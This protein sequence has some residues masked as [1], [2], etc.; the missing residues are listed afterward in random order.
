M[1]PE[2]RPPVT[3]ATTPRAVRADARPPVPA[4]V[5]DRY[6][7]LS[8]WWRTRPSATRDRELA[9]V[10]AVLSFAAP[11]DSVGAQFGDLPVRQ[12]G[13][14]GVLLTLGQTLPL[15][16]R[17]RRPALCLTLVA[18]CFALHQTCAHPPNIGS[19]GLYVALYSV[20][21]HQERWR[22]LLPVP[23]VAAYGVFAVVLWRLDSPAGIA[24]YA[25][26]ALALAAFWVAGAYVRARRAEEAERRRLAALAATAEERARLARELH[27]VVTHHVTAMVVQADAAQYLAASPDRLTEG[28]TAISGTGRRA[29]TELRYLLG[30]LEATGESATA[31]RAPVRGKLSD[32]VEQTRLSGQPVVLVEEGQE[33]GERVPMGI[34]GEL[35]AYRVVQESLTNAVKYAAGRPTRVRVRYGHDHMDIE[36]TTDGP[37]GAARAPL[38]S[39]AGGHV[40]GGRGLGG[41]RE[42]VDMLGGRFTA[43]AGSDGGFTVTARIPVG[44]S[45]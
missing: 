5:A 35:A 7:S 13:V 29:L 45:A 27:D 2:S 44:E 11:L 31:E 14:A 17:A 43:D 26:H 12:A 8:S 24:D 40:S 21:A 10:L 16:V 3:R 41:L 18:L 9:A 38:G 22:R 19:L 20:G 33:E 36:I 23:A 6:R 42:R 28:L 30:V 34:G 1:T 25:V 4:P 32:L 37:D 15:A 39:G